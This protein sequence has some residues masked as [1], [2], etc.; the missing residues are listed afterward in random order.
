MSTAE[1]AVEMARTVEE[2]PAET[3]GRPYAPS[4]VNHLTAWIE[5]LPGPAWAF[6]LVAMGVAVLVQWS[7]GWWTGLIPQGEVSPAYAYYGIALPATVWLIAHLDRVAADALRGFRPLLGASPDEMRR[8]QHELTVI[9]ARPAAI[10]TIA[11]YLFTFAYYVGDPV[12]SDTVGYTVPMLLIRGFWEGAVGALITILV[13]H[14]IR[15]LRLVSRLHE[16]ARDVPLFEPA[17][18]YAFSTLTART[19][20][21]LVLLQA[22]GFLFVPD[23]ESAF[24]VT[25]VWMTVL[26][27]ISA[28]IF[29]LPLRG[30]QQR[31]ASEKERLEAEVGRRLVTTIADVHAAVDGR[32]RED[33]DALNKTLATLITERDLVAKLPTW[34]WSAGAFWG[35]ASAVI[36]PIGLWFV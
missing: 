27:A 14:S 5:R 10:I 13:Y 30:M 17:P 18:L 1:S 33:A 28:A 23:N 3:S 2:T 26:T 32:P 25:L 36:L 22:P 8:W 34:P 19:A 24:V 15:Q 20:I 31:I 6:Y 11:V 4:W 35:F 7:F 21:G 16:G 29:L 12:A 9:P